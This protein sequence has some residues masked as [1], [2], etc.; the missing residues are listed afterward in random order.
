MS[1]IQAKHCHTLLMRRW[2]FKIGNI[3]HKVSNS[4]ITAFQPIRAVY[5]YLYLLL[6][7]CQATNVTFYCYEYL[8][9]KSF[10]RKYFVWFMYVCLEKHDWISLLVPNLVY[11]YVIVIRG[12][13]K[14]KYDKRISIRAKCCIVH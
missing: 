7:V 2:S 5:I 3:N 4:M 8:R 10:I 9:G 13:H 6:L 11:M 14:F 12:L 1:M